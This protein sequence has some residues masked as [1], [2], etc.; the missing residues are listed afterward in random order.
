MS[1]CKLF[2]WHDHDQR[3]RRRPVQPALA[4]GAGQILSR[5]FVVQRAGSR[6]R[7]KGTKGVRTLSG[8][9]GSFKLRMLL[10]AAKVTAR[11]EQYFPS[12][13]AS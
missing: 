5:G 13:P 1:Y 12:H 4:G 3:A 9:A 6:G 10:A 2:R 7:A 11:P 8:S